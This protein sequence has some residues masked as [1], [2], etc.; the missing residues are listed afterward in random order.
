MGKKVLFKIMSKEKYD[1]LKTKDPC[2][3]YFTNKSGSFSD[4]SED[5]SGELYLGAKKIIGKRGIN[6]RSLT[7]SLAVVKN[8]GNNL[9]ERVID[10]PAGSEVYVRVCYKMHQ[11][12][13]DNNMAFLSITDPLQEKCYASTSSYFPPFGNA[14]TT[15]SLYHYFPERTE[16]SIMAMMTS[17]TGIILSKEEDS[18]Y[19]GSTSLIIKT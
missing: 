13:A 16:I 6:V 15:L 5:E 1:A 14:E 4:E 8:V 18:I 7:N 19:G 11:S 3:L 2:K 10:I 17:D 9:F 12:S